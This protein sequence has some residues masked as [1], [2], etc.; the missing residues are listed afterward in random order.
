MNKSLEGRIEALERRLGTRGPK[1]PRVIWIRAVGAEGEDEASYRFGGP[2]FD[3]N[4]DNMLERRPGET[5]DAFE[6]RIKAAFPPK[7]KGDVST[8]LLTSER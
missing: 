5:L 7:R 2:A 8:Y 4:R 1:W 3:G 6:E